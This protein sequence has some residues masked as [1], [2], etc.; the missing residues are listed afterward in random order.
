[1]KSQEK[2][3]ALLST[4]LDVATALNVIGH[5]SISIGAACC[6]RLIYSEKYLDASG[7]SHLGVSAWPFIVL[8]T[9]PTKLRVALDQARRMPSLILADYPRQVLTTS[10]DSELAAAIAAS[11][12]KDLEYLGLMV[13]GNAQDVDAIFGTFALV[14]GNADIK[15]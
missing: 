11:A 13:H 12:E 15:L 10:T 1:M 9:R 5:L 4:E 3:V 14:N 2:T 6:E 8:K 7:Y